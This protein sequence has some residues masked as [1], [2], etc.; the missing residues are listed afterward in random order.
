M[1]IFTIPNSFNSKFSKRQNLSHLLAISFWIEKY[2]GGLR[3][4]LYPRG[5]EKLQAKLIHNQKTLEILIPSPYLSRKQIDPEGNKF[6]VCID[7]G[8]GGQDPGSQGKSDDEKDIVLKVSRNLRDVINALPGMVAYLTR[9]SDYKIELPDRAR[10][11]NY[12]GADV[13]ISLHMN[14]I[15][16][17]KPNGFEIFYISKKG[18]LDHKKVSLKTEKIDILSTRREKSQNILQQILIDLQQNQTV[19]E[20]ALFAQS[21]A[22]EMKKVK[23][24]RNRGVRR[25]S[26]IVLKNIETPSV[27]IELGFITN[28]KDL[29]YFKSKSSRIEMCK[30]I[31]QG[32]INFLKKYKSLPKESGTSFYKDSKTPILTKYPKFVVEYK[33]YVVRPGDTFLKLV[34]KFKVSYS[35]LKKANPK[36]NPDRLYVGKTLK[37][38]NIIQ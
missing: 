25:D 12:A 4:K 18:A 10:V 2:R 11:S 35:R 26:F 3:F 38:P 6:V 1:H 13:F 14:A 20:S 29:D 5:V 22:Y 33:R 16:N 9:N 37:I 17:P 36:I 15:D 19:N 32:V 24:R 23:S 21:L 34:K 8:H 31:S 7:A 28:K 30:R 27:L